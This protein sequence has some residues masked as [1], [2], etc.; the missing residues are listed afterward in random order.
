MSGIQAPYVGIGNFD[1]EYEDPEGYFDYHADD[2]D[3]CVDE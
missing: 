1:D 2:N 3:D